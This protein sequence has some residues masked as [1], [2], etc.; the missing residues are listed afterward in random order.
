MGRILR[1]YKCNS[2]NIAL[3]PELSGKCDFE[4]QLLRNGHTYDAVDSSLEY[5]CDK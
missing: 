4:F 3:L 2:L 5:L 1:K